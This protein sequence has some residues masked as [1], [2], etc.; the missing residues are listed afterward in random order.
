MPRI[1]SGEAR[2]Q[3]MEAVRLSAGSVALMYSSRRATWNSRRV[4]PR[5]DE[6]AA[7]AAYSAVPETESCTAVVRPDG[8]PGMRTD[9]RMGGWTV[10]MGVSE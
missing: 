4:A 5:A 8:G 1:L 9:G 6:P 7:N 3:G 2:V 10:Y